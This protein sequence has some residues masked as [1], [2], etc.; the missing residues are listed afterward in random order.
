ML[1]FG[2]GSGKFIELNIVQKRK[3][4]K[5]RHLAVSILECVYE[6][7]TFFPL[8]NLLNSNFVVSLNPIWTVRTGSLFLIAT[9]TK[10]LFRCFEGICF[11][12]R[13]YDAIGEGSC[14]GVVYV[15]PK[16]VYEANGER[17][18]FNL[19]SP[20]KKQDFSSKGILALRFRHASIEDLNF[21]AELVRDE[22]A[23]LFWKPNIKIG[24]ILMRNVKA[25]M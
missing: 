18:E 3:C 8:P 17:L 25:G 10:E 21:M 20:S 15:P 14:L 4:S 22:T 7:V 13:D 6:C 5:T 1:W 19:Q 12:V 23:D 16:V 9:T 2:W 24:N 11:E